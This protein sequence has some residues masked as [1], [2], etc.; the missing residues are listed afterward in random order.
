M[1]KVSVV[2]LVLIQWVLA[3]EWLHSGWSKW[4][5]PGFIAN[6]GKTLE[7]FAAK[8][9]YA[10]YSDFLGSTAI[11]HAQLFGNIIRIGEMASGIA[12]ALSGIILLSQKRL[13]EWATWILAII[14]FGAALMNLNFFLASGWSSPSTWGI[15]VLM[16]LLHLILGIYYVTNRRELAS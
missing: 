3:F 15:N 14:S 7:G 16:G 6:I 2:W 11:P 10:A 13:P 8:T 5:G 12:F 9:P 1:K 4:S